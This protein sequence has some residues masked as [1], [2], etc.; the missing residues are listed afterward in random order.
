MPIGEDEVAAAYPT[1]AILLFTE[2]FTPVRM[3]EVAPVKSN[4]TNPKLVKTGHAV[5][6]LEN[7]FREEYQPFAEVE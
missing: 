6:G 1:I 2:L 4:P 3:L 5:D 7:V